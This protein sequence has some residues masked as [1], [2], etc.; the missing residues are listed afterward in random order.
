MLCVSCL[1]APLSHPNS[2]RTSLLPHLSGWINIESCGHRVSTTTSLFFSCLSFFTLVQ[3]SFLLRNKVW[4]LVKTT[5]EVQRNKRGKETRGFD[6]CVLHLTRWSVWLIHGYGQAKNRGWKNWQ[7]A[8]YLLNHRLF[9]T[10]LWLYIHKW[11]QHRVGDLI[12]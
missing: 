3:G 8:S 4:A 7:Y 1:H 12:I 10:L 11:P 9:H 5:Y 6:N 2:S